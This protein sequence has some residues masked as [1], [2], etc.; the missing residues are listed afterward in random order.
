MADHRCSLLPWCLQLERYKLGASQG[1]P[2]GPSFRHRA[3]KMQ[4]ELGRALRRANAASARAGALETALVEAAEQRRA[5]LEVLK[6]VR[7]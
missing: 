4:M 7:L 3:Y 6:E 5:V 2:S 1:G